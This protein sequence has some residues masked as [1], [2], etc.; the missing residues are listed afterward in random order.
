MP[1]N[2][3]AKQ[4]ITLLLIVK[5]VENKMPVAGKTACGQF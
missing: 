4:F 5:S 1:A 2:I 3:H